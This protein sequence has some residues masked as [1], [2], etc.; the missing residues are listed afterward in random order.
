MSQIHPAVARGGLAATR[1][2]LE[3]LITRLTT[4]LPRQYAAT[5]LN[6]AK[7]LLIPLADERH[8]EETLL[9]VALANQ[10]DDPEYG[11]VARDLL[12]RR[13]YRDALAS[14]TPTLQAYRAAFATYLEQ[15]VEQGL[16]DV[17]LLAFAEA[18]AW[19][20][21]ERDRSIKYL[22]LA[23][24]A[25]RY[26]IKEVESAQLIETPQFLF[27][28]VAL[29]T[30]LAEG[31]PLEWAVRFYERMSTLRYLPGTPTLFNAGTPH[32]QL[33]SCYVYDIH[34]DLTHILETT[35]DFGLLAK[36]AG[37]VGT[38]V[39]KLRAMGSPVRGV[40][41][42]SSGLIPFINMY[43]ALFKA[44]DQGGRRRGT[45]AVYLEPWHLELPEFLD[46]RRNSGDHY[47]RAHSIDTV[48]WISDEFMRRV[49]C[50]EPWTL[51]DPAVAEDLTELYGN[52]YAERYGELERQ[53]Q[54]GVLPARSFRVVRAR[55]T[56][57]QILA[58]LQ[59]TSHPWITFKDAFNA[60]SPNKQVGVIH[61]SNLCTEIGLP[62]DKDHI[63]VCNL[64]S[65]NLAKHVT[66][67]ALDWPELETSVR[68]AVRQLD[69]VIDVNF[70]PSD[71]AARSN[72]HIRPIGLGVMG[73]A[74]LTQ[75]LGFA[76]GSAKARQLTSDVFAFMNYH[77]TDESANLAQDKGTYPA[78][79]GSTWSHG[80]LTA[81]T[82]TGADVE[83]RFV[84]ETECSSLPLD[85]PALREKVGRG[86]R[87]S[88]VSAVAPTATI[89]L[90]AG[91][92]PSL[93]PYFANVFARNTLSGKFLEFNPSLVRDLKARGLWD[94]VKDQLI[95]ERGDL[96]FLDVPQ[97]LKD[98]YQTA[99]RIEPDAYLDIAARAQVYVD[100][101]I[102][103]NMYLTTRDVGEMREV[104]LS[105]WKRGL[106]STYYLFMQPRMSAEQSTVA[107]NKTKKKPQW[108]GLLHQS[109][110]QAS[111]PDA[112]T[113]A[114]EEGCESCQ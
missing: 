107:V 6:D 89:G 28:R 14:P 10:R 11:M 37:G 18:A 29:G 43:D 96:T 36:Y 33:S 26:L 9:H 106:K 59:E 5:L 114:L 46:L 82:L 93:D 68:L 22:G 4:S 111:V 48:L 79:A 94:K 47:R 104:Y 102:S 113:C 88:V 34:D 20:E 100:Q 16:L 85:W 30:A 24:L 23:T 75:T 101:G 84:A 41:G 8:L 66:D 38:S 108:V 58:A 92:S 80:Q 40:S 19:L 44:I 73:F 62:T 39:A 15:G 49:E 32:H 70:Y 69:N 35:R 27:M 57:N 112:N 64:A 103:R 13:I 72:H 3:S 99:F 45:L 109:A 97:E 2:R 60:R 86:M 71:K 74:E 17:R 52:A 54:A 90:I 61:S 77:A 63:A 87:N 55:E 95:A 7:P 81:D 110:Q 98:L 105:A 56:M 67:G 50:D 1:S 65:I 12:L 91:T 76:Y 51:F 21:P 78:F 42:K 53:A 83:R 25:D 31:E